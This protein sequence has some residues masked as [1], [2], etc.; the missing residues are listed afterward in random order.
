MRT[1]LRTVLILDIAFGLTLLASAPAFAQTTCM[2]DN[3]QSIESTSN[4]PD[5]CASDCQLVGA[6]GGAPAAPGYND[7]DDDDGDGN[8]IVPPRRE[9]GRRRR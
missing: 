5:A 6:A 1:I 2:C 8:V 3:G 7:D 9:V 4:A